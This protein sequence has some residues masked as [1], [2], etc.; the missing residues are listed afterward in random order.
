MA[1][2]RQILA[3]ELAGAMRRFNTGARDL[4]RERS[5]HV[6]LDGSFLAHLRGGGESDVAERM[7]EPLKENCCG[8]RM[9]W[10]NCPPIN[11]PASNCTNS[12]KGTGSPTWPRC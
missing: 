3:N 7:R 6:N 12:C 11:A 2:L 9:A 4:G 5:V 10:R 8:W 1:W